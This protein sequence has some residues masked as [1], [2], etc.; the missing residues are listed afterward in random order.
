MVGMF[1]MATFGSGWLCCARL[2]HQSS[3]SG[4]VTK[5]GSESL[6][7]TMS[8]K[9]QILAVLSLQPHLLSTSSAHKLKFGLVFELLLQWVRIRESVGCS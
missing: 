3:S 9:E 4:W 6:A 7:G 1:R 8:A 2:C 5:Q